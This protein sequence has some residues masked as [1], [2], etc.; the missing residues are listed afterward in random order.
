[1]PTPQTVSSTREGRQK[2][3]AGGH[4]WLPRESRNSWP[5]WNYDDIRKYKWKRYQWHS[6]SSRVGFSSALTK[7]KWRKCVLFFVFIDFIQTSCLVLLLALSPSF[8][9][10]NDVICLY[11]K[12]YSHL[13]LLFIFQERLVVYLI[14]YNSCIL[15]E[16][17]NKK[18]DEKD[19]GF[20]T[21]CIANT[22]LDGKIP[23]DTIGKDKKNR[24]KV[25][26]DCGISMRPHFRELGKDPISC[27]PKRESLRPR[28][29]NAQGRSHI[30]APLDDW[31]AVIQIFHP[32]VTNRSLWIKSR[33]HTVHDPKMIHCVGTVIFLFFR[34]LQLYHPF[35]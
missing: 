30:P 11:I 29:L 12:P 8:L 2:N 16:S 15:R 19:Y 4:A 3:D 18:N 34:I 10:K 14:Y 13:F 9:K 33:I 6:I 20:S 28:N 7:C 26:W 32:R 25:L 17:V 31:P 5:L 27:V 21:E 1:M 35:F 22:E 24:D 23:G